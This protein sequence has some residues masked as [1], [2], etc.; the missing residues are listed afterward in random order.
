MLTFE[1]ISCFIL[2]MSEAQKELPGDLLK[3]TSRTF[4]LTLR[5]LPVRCIKK[6]L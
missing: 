2:A 1:D 5:V 4:Y 3:A 6:P